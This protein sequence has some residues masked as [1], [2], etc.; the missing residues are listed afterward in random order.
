MPQRPY[1][2]LGTLRAAVAYPAGER[3]F[4]AR[5]LKAVLQRCGLDHLIGR[6]GERER[7]DRVLS[8]GEQQRLAFARLLLHKPEWVFM[9]EA[10]GALDE[11]AQESL[12]G[13]FADELAGTTVV[14]IAHR[15]GMDAFHERTLTLVQSVGGARLVTRRRPP[16]ARQRQTRRGRILPNF[17]FRRLH[18][19]R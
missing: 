1:L 4:S 17:V 2:P 12:M 5:S 9:D 10:T 7:W 18:S 8:G 3:K 19:T 13:L 15:P 11:E 6:L 16:P 14:S